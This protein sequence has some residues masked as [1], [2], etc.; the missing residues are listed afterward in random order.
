MLYRSADAHEQT[1]PMLTT[2]PLGPRAR[3]A[4]Q[5]EAL[6]GSG[7]PA[8]ISA[9]R[10]AEEYL[11]QVRERF[12][13]FELVV[14]DDESP[15]AAGWAVPIAWDGT[16]DGLPAGYGDSL[17]RALEG[18]DGGDDPGRLRCAGSP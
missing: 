13:G 2:E 1:E 16:R 6:F 11:P 18:G 7:W 17:R 15:V 9:D 8:F 10:L 14:L 5:M 3:D 4:G 12:T